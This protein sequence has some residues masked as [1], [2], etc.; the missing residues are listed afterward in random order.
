MSVIDQRHI[1]NI[2]EETIS[3]SV[4]CE[5]LH[6]DGWGKGDV[7]EQE[8]VTKLLNWYALVNPSDNEAILSSVFS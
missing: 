1:A 2:H 5:L 8:E 4:A 6:F 7:V 3:F